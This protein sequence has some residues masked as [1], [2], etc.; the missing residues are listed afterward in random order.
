[1]E[2][3]AEFF[4]FLPIREPEPVVDEMV[5]A[6]LTNQNMLIPSYG[7]RVLLFFKS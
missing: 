6:I 4:R 7:V 2:R 5:D 1:M 3:N